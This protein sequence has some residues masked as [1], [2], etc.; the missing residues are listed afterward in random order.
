[1]KKILLRPLVLFL[2]SAF[3]LVNLTSC[4]EEE[5]PEPTNNV[6]SIIFWQGK[7]NAED[8]LDLGITSFKFYVAGELVGSMA[9]DVYWN[10]AP[11]CGATSAVNVTWQLGNRDS[12]TVTY[13]IQ[14]Q[15]NEVVY[16]GSI[17]VEKDQCT[18]FEMTP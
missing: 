13:E 15:D 2:F 18:Q 12:Q 9:A 5:V 6:G 3:A 7:T 16:S 8:N 17:T 10:V 11:D 1:M 14:N 4:S